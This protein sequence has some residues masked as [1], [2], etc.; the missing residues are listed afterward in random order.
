[1]GWTWEYIDEFMTLPRLHDISDYW[2]HSP[3]THLMARTISMILGAEP[4][5]RKEETETLNLDDDEN[6]ARFL[7]S[8]GVDVRA[9]V[10]GANGG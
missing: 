10:E 3:P 4:P 1:M 8:F 6:V 2:Q 7:Q 9:I 5:K